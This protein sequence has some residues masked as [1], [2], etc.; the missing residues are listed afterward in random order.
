M[1]HFLI[2]VLAVVVAVAVSVGI[3]GRLWQ[4]KVCDYCRERMGWILVDR[5]R[6]Q[7]W[8]RRQQTARSRDARD[9][10]TTALPRVPAQY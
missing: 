6:R 10:D 8:E 3:C 5:T 7:Q 9:D 4:R 2:T 1:T